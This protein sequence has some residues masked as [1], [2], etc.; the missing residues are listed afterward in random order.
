MAGTHS[1]RGSFVENPATFRKSVS[2]TLSSITLELSR[3]SGCCHK[4]R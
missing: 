1:S 3:A 2:E 4:M